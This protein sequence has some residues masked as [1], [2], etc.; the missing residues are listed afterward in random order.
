MFQYSTVYGQQK[1]WYSFPHEKIEDM[2]TAI[3]TVVFG[4]KSSRGSPG[5]ATPKWNGRG[6]LPENLNSTPGEWKGEDKATLCAGPA[7]GKKTNMLIST[8]ACLC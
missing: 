5:G 6:C 4:L 7:G 3:T 1:I 8:A 2:Y